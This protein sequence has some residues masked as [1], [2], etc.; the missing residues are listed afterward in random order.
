MID[1]GLCAL[2]HLLYS[3]NKR[4]TNKMGAGLGKRKGPKPNVNKDASYEK[5]LTSNEDPNNSKPRLHNDD[6]VLTVAAYENVLFTGG[7]DARAFAYDLRSHSIVARFDDHSNAVLKTIPSSSGALV[8]TGSRDAKIFARKARDSECARRFD[9]HTLSVTGVAVAASDDRLASG[10]RD[11]SVR[12]WDVET[13]KCVAT[14]SI[15][16]NVVTHVAWIGESQSAFVQTSEDKI[17]KIWDSRIGDVAQTFPLQRHIHL[18]C[19]V[20]NDGHVILTSSSGSRGDGCR[21]TI[22]DRRRGDAAIGDLIGHEAPVTCAKFLP[23]SMWIGGG[24]TALSCS[25]DGAVRV[26]DLGACTCLSEKKLPASGPLTSAC[27]C[28][29]QTVACASHERG[30]LLLDKHKSQDYLL[31]IVLNI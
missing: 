27:V 30:V 10:S 5:P 28:E 25:N 13:G 26:W 11:N 9:G 18:H 14:K 7:A 1:R 17:V 16:R 21:V 15:S 22:W 2:A 4:P 12:I 3:T 29:N 23:D 20:E 19:D 8:F 6:E 24:K 31:D